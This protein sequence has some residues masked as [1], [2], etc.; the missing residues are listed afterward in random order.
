MLGRRV[1][2]CRVVVIGD[3]PKDVDAA[4]DVGAEAIG[5]GT[6]S[7]SATQLLEHGAKRAFEDLKAPGALA[8][9]LG[10]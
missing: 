5:V 10:E 7:F 2:D 6:G 8:A 3:T 4:R 9:L 1:A